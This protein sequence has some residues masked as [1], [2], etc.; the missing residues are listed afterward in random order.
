MM[1]HSFFSNDDI[2]YSI[3]KGFNDYSRKQNLN[4]TLKINLFS[5]KNSTQQSDNTLS[6]TEQLL[7]RK[8]QK[9]DLYAFN[10]VYLSDLSKHFMDLK[11]L[12][13]SE[14]IDSFSKNNIYDI[15]VYN[16]K[17]IG[18]PLFIKF[19]VLYSNKH[20]LEKYDK[21]IPK[22]WDELLEIG[23]YIVKQEKLNNTNLY[24][25]NGLFNYYSVITMDSI[26]QFI[27]SYR[28]ER[29]SE[30]P[31]ITS[32][33]SINALR[34]IK[35]IKEKISSDE[36]FKQNEEYTIKLLNEGNNLLFASYWNSINEFDMYDQSILPG[37][38]ED[39]NGSYLEGYNIGLSKYIDDDHKLASIEVLKYIFSEGFQKE[40]IIK[41]FNQYSGILNL[42]KNEDICSVVKCEIMN[43]IQFISRPTELNNYKQ[44]ESKFMSYFFEFLYGDKDVEKV[45]QSINNITK[46]Y[47]MNLRSIL[48]I[49]LFIIMNIFLLLIIASYILSI[50]PKFKPYYSLYSKF[51]WINYIF[52]SIFI[53]YSPL[54]KIGRPTGF[55]CHAFLLMILIGYTMLYVPSIALLIVN[56][57]SFNNK[58]CSWLKNNE[59][60]FIFLFYGIEGILF[61]LS[62]ITP[63][64]KAVEIITEDTLNF[65]QCKISTKDKYGFSLLIIEISFHI[66]LF[67]SFVMLMLADWNIQPIHPI[68]KSML[69]FSVTDGLSFLVSFILQALN[70]E[71]YYIDCIHPLSILIVFIL[72]HIYLYFVRVWFDITNSKREKEEMLI[73]NLLKMSSDKDAGGDTTVQI[74]K[75][76][77]ILDRDSVNTTNIIQTS[78]IQEKH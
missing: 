27:Y 42:Y 77:E 57:P 49:S 34:K 56:N 39:I 20:Y 32:K 58:F 25:Y 71:N 55:R 78:T 33:N 45:L 64:Y 28:D 7:N 47:Y 16:D 35:E 38:T 22:T 30:F 26:Y 21:K 31:E 5:N 75:E 52:S 10:S 14:L 6:S 44:Y 73:N 13:P 4:I 65:Y 18:L 24:G 50:I 43:N 74:V 63:S 40:V 70:T 69:Y 48:G 46:M 59:K 41:Q 29:N 19:M 12:L 9:Y 66:V 3:E 68:V 8:S 62:S 15:C 37:R 23:Q 67:L 53:I 61:I 72:K 17:W 36:I 51:S 54:T 2:F 76:K 11:E 60:K 1:L